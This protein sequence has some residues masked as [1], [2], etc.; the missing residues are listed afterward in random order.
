MDSQR[1]SRAPER[2]MSLLVAALWSIAFT[3][4]CAITVVV[5]NTVRPGAAADAVNLAACYLLA[6]SLVIFA[7]VR[8]HARE[9]SLRATLGFRGIAPLHL[10]LSVAAGAGLRPLLSTLEDLILR[11]YPYTDVEQEGMKDAAK[12]FEVPT[13]ASRIALVVYGCVVLPVV[14]EVFFRGALFG[15]LSRVVPRQTA[16]V[17][18]SAFFACWQLDWRALPTA[19]VLGLALARL[20]DRSGTVLAP[21]VGH[22]SYAAV[23]GVPLLRGLDPNADVTYPRRWIVGGAVIAVLALVGMQAGSGRVERDE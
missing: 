14:L 22:L 3:G 11:R 21:L 7:I 18:T 23:I 2:P 6:T 5:T 1:P 17:A 4:V 10:L 20:R 16:I 12:L 13:Q 9:E 15:R 8:I 19:F